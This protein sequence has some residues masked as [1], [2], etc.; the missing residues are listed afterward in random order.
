MK[1]FHLQVANQL[2]YVTRKHP[3]IHKD[4]SLVCD[5]IAKP[6]VEYSIKASLAQFIKYSVRKGGNVD[7]NR[8]IHIFKAN[9]DL[10]IKSQII[11]ALGYK[12]INSK[13]SIER[14]IVEDI[15][16]LLHENL[17]PSDAKKFL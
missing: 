13:K 2:R 6:N 5:D 16:R 15:E 7:F 3:V 1:S 12:I 11:Y 14:N 4:L 9:K 10:H 8:L 17:V